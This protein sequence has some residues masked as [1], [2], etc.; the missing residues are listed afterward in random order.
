MGP[1]ALCAIQ[2]RERL[3]RYPF[4][5]AAMGEFELRRRRFEAARRFLEKRLKSC[6]EDDLQAREEDRA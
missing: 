6:L 4:Y 5:P 2:D 3:D 1:R